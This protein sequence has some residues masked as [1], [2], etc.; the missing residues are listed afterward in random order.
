MP[1][2]AEL[3]HSGT[4]IS[5]TP[6]KNFSKNSYV[7]SREAAAKLACGACL[8]PMFVEVV[9]GVVKGVFQ[10][11]NLARRSN[12]IEAGGRNR[13]IHPLFSAVF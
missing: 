1:V 8:T 12:V 7:A 11:A 2:I 9:K 6:M 13:P 4:E 5:D 3:V 10:I